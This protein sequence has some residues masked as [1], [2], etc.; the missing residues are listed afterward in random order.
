MVEF[1]KGPRTAERE[2]PMHAVVVRASVSDPEGSREA[3]REDVVPRTSAQD[4]FVAGYWLEPVDGKGLAVIVF[5]DEDAA[6][7]INEAVQGMIQSGEMPTSSAKI[8]SSEVR[9]VVAHA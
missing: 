9:E 7:R 5:E 2:V 4:G 6:R 1:V 8:E 3:L